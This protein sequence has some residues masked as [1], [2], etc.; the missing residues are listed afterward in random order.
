MKITIR[1][2]VTIEIEGDIE[3]AEKIARRYE[4]IGYTRFE[5]TDGW[6]QLDKHIRMD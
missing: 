3:S 5:E 6:I 1:R 4:K 2:E